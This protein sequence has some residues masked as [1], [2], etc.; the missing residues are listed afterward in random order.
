MANNLKHSRGFN[1]HTGIQSSWPT[2][3]FLRMRYLAEKTKQ[4][5]NI[6]VTK[7]SMEQKNI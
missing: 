4:K 6:N 3:P 2:A 5:E 1:N 7:T